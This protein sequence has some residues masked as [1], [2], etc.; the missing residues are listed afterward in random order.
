MDIV[1]IR[2]LEIK[3]IIGCYESEKKQAQSLIIDL[4]MG[5]DIG[6]AAHT[7]TLED[8]LDYNAVRLGI[9]ALCEKN[10]FELVEALAERIASFVMESF[11]VPGLRLRVAKPEAIDNTLDVGILISRGETLSK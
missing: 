4:E 6:R 9:E 5:W 2:G 10:N 8:A 3:T 11:N 1:F 7:D